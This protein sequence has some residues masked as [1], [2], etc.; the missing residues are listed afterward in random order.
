MQ[1]I[2]DDLLLLNLDVPETLHPLNLTMSMAVVL[3]VHDFAD[4]EGEE[5]EGEETEG[6][7]SVG[8]GLDFGEEGVLCGGFL[9]GIGL[10]GANGSL[11]WWG[12]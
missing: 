3:S 4:A 5:V 11:D 10:E 9:V 6:V 8:D 2:A 1:V 12:G 7:V